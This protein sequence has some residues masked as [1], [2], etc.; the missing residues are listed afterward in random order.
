MSGLALYVDATT[1]VDLAALVVRSR[2]TV[3]EATFVAVEGRPQSV[4]VRGGRLASAWQLEA[5]FVDD[6]AAAPFLGLL[7]AAY[8]APDGRLRLEGAEAEP[9]VVEVHAWETGWDD[10]ATHV[11]FE[12]REVA[13]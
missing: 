12:A 6:V 2:S 3:G 4:S 1:R 8:A 7:A 13:P 9:V 11:S 5:V 10:A